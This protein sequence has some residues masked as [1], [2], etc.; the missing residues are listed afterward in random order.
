MTCNK[1]R[2]PDCGKTAYRDPDVGLPDFARSCG[3]EEGGPTDYGYLTMTERPSAP[4]DELVAAACAL[5]PGIAD[6]LARR[7]L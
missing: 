4:D 3:W 6:E 5:D 1:R 2:C 7:G